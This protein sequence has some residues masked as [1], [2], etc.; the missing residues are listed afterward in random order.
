M[1]QLCIFDLDGTLVYTLDDIAEALNMAL[2]SCELPELPAYRVSAIVGHSTKYMFQHAVPEDRSDE[3]E[4]VGRYYD[5]YYERHCCDAS[6]P[7]EGILGVMAA[8]KKAGLRLAVVSN[9]P[10]RD[11]LSVI[12]TLF[13]R[14]TFSLVLG[15]MERFATKPSPEP[16]AF[17]LDYFGVACADAVYVGDS[18]VDVAFARNAGVDCLSV[19]WGYRTRQELVDAGAQRILDDPQEIADVLL[20]KP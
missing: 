11:T 7:Y 10:H 18:E 5:A 12:N 9:K 13:P 16:L 8:L 2:K 15:R 3:W 17:V 1:K 19:A 6:H 20:A 14:D 4:R